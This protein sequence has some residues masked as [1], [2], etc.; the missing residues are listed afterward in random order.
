MLNNSTLLRRVLTCIDRLDPNNVPNP[1][2]GI[3]RNLAVISCDDFIQPAISELKII[4]LVGKLSESWE[5]YSGDFNYPVSGGV[6][7]NI[8]KLSNKLWKGSQY[9]L[10]VSLLRHLAV[11]IEARIMELETGSVNVREAIN[12]LINRDLK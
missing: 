6:K 7:Y 3:C 12:E 10:R 1:D 4:K 5:H 11:N 2:S 9:H 8:N